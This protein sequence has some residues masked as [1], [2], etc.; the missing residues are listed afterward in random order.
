MSWVYVLELT[1][2][3][4]YVGMSQNVAH[5]IQKHINGQGAMATRQAPVIDIHSITKFDDL[6][7]AIEGEKVEYQRQCLL[8]GSKKVSM[9]KQFCDLAPIKKKA[10][11]KRKWVPKY[12]FEEYFL[13][14]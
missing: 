7:G 12:V 14:R 5:R 4:F 3:R 9:G 10:T 13:K 11:R 6:S 1:G 8:H 2:G